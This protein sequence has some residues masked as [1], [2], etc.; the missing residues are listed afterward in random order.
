M[1]TYIRLKRKNQTI[2]MHVEPSDNFSSIKQRVAHLMSLEPFQVM[3]IGSDKKKELVDLSTLSD[4]GKR[5]YFDVNFYLEF[6]I[7]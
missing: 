3:L 2:F 4:Q 6:S 1:T 7:S 5:M